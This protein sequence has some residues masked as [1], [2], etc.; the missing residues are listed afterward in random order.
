MRIES[1]LLI[2]ASDQAAKSPTRIVPGFTN[3]IMSC[4]ISGNQLRSQPKLMVRASMA[5][6]EI[7]ENAT[8]QMAIRRPA[9]FSNHL[10]MPALSRSRYGINPNPSN[11]MV[12][13]PIPP[14]KAE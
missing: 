1:S 14:M 4:G 7:V 9:S 2:T 3:V 13:M 5:T 10:P 11:A 8:D 12:G 6:Q